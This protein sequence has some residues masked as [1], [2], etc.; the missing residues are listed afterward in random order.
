MHKINR[1]DF[2]KTGLATVCSINAPA[3]LTGKNNETIKAPE[4]ITKSQHIAS[5]MLADVNPHLQ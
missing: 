2:L 4:D 1:R 3:F 5:R